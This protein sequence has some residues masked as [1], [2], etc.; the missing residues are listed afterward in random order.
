M[1]NLSKKQVMATNNGEVIK[2]AES[3][4]N[5]LFNQV[6]TNNKEI[7]D[8]YLR[9]NDEEKEAIKLMFVIGSGIM[10]SMQLAK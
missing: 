1:K 4:Y 7:A 8:R 3:N 6:M 10:T 9:G 5:Y 2:I